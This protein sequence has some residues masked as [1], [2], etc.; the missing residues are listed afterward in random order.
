M[1]HHPRARL[2]ASFRLAVSAASCALVLTA[3]AQ[4]RVTKIVFDSAPTAL[5]G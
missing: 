1:P 4:A 2:G 5:P 3:P